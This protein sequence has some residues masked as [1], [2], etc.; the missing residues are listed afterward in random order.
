MALS[1]RGVQDEYSLL[2]L[3]PPLTKCHSGLAPSEL[4]LPLN[5]L[6]ETEE[7]AGITTRSADWKL[8]IASKM[9]SGTSVRNR[10]LSERLKMG[11]LRAVSSN[12]SVYAKRKDECPHFRRLKNIT[13]DV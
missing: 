4:L 3:P 7:T 5:A 2:F 9:K 11:V 1:L 8:A 12:C 6:S 10:W 13:F